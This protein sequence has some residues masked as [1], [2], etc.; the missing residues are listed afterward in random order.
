MS[1]YTKLVASLGD[2]YLDALSEMQENVLKAVTPLTDWT[3]SLQAAP[4][5]GFAADFPTPREITEAN[6]AFA[7]KLLKQQKKFADRLFAAATPAGKSA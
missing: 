7:T 6:F 1:E 4:V 2:Q 5:T 3:S